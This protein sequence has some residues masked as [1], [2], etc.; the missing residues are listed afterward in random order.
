MAS[1]APVSAHHRRG[2]AE[3]AP[4]RG[5]AGT[6]CAGRGRKSPDLLLPRWHTGADRG[7]QR[8]EG[9]HLSAPKLVFLWKFVRRWRGWGPVPG[10]SGTRAPWR[11]T[12]VAKE[13]KRC[14]TGRRA[15]R[16]RH[17]MDM[18]TRTMISK[19]P[20]PHARLFQKA[21]VAS[22]TRSS[23]V[24]VDPSQIGLLSPLLSSRA[25]ERTTPFFF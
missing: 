24:R 23:G 21:S 14:E 20:N 5:V 22:S 3:S 8:C 18:K 1:G 25:N 17:N 7:W 13:L 4:R 16:F 19:H 11:Y 6:P 15:G 12:A 2:A 9:P 10:V